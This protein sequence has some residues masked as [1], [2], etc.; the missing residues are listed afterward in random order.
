MLIPSRKQST[1]ALIRVCE[2]A[3]E[4]GRKPEKL[5]A[6]LPRARIE[7]VRGS[8]RRHAAELIR[9]QNSRHNKITMDNT[10]S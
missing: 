5:K 10:I 6:R 9:M 1:Q 7:Y 3:A 8:E 2:S 4:V